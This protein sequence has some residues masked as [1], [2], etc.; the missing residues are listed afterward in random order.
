MFGDN[1]SVVTSSTVPHSKLQ[2]RHL[3][4]SYHRVRTAISAKILEFHFIDGVDNP[5]DICSKHWDYQQVW[6]LLK[7][8]LFWKGDPAEIVEGKEEGKEGKED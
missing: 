2:K 7:P 8:L 1:Q 6:K 5:A 4:L 3:D